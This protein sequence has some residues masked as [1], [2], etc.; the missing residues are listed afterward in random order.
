MLVSCTTTGVN[1]CNLPP[2]YK[3]AGARTLHTVLPRDTKCMQLLGVLAYVYTTW[4]SYRLK[5]Q[6]Y[7]QHAHTRHTSWWYSSTQS[8][9]EDR[10]LYTHCTGAEDWSKSNKK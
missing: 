3:I 1:S 7:R 5:I 8:T 6:T 4:R 10:T 9:D 2:Y